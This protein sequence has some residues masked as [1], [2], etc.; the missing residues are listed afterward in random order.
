MGKIEEIERAREE[1]VEWIGDLTQRLGWKDRERLI[2]AFVAGLHALR[3]CLP[4]EE[5]VFLGSHLP[6]LLRGFYYEGW[7]PAREPEAL[8]TR[9]ALVG[10]IHDSVHRDPGIDAEEVARAI[11]ALLADRL[12]PEELEDV[13]AVTPRPLRAFW[14]S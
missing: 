5:A 1:T 6:T 13:K 8:G 7:H 10:R 2:L 4:F 12:P 11:F 9:D 3:D 14:P